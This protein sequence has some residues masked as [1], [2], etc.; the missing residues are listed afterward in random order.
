MFFLPAE[1]PYGE[2]DLV[3]SATD[4]VTGYTCEYAVMRRLDAL[5]GRIEVEPVKDAMLR[6]VTDL[7]TRH[8]TEVLESLRPRGVYEVQASGRLSRTALLARHEDTL[9]ALAGDHGVIY[10]ASFFDGSFHG[11]AD[12]L[13]REQD[14]S[15]AVHDTKLA[16]SAKAPALMQLAA[17]ADQLET[18]GVKVHPE[19][20]LILGSGQRSS[21]AL[22]DLLPGYRHARM[23]LSALLHDHLDDEDP[24]GWGDTRWTACLTC[25]ECKAAIAANDD[26]MLI[27]GMNRTRRAR[28][29]AA[30]T[31]TMHGFAS[32]DFLGGDRIQDTLY[33]QARLQCGMGN[34]AGTINGVSFRF[35]VPHTLSRI[36]QADPGDIFFDFE[37]DPLYQDPATKEWGLEY[38][39]G[40]LEHGP[41]GGT[42]F[43]AFTAHDY[44]AEKQALIDFIT[45][46][47]Q[48]V[49]EHPGL[50]IY[51][52]ASYEV[53]ALRR[54]AARHGVMSAEVEWLVEAGILFDLYEIVKTSLMISDRSLSIKKLEP[55][56]MDGHRTGTAT[57]LDSIT[58]YADYRA[59][60][61]NGDTG[62]AESIF[63]D[64]LAYNEYDC[65]STMKLRDWLQGLPIGQ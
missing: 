31:D 20:V 37:G 44:A 32:T 39:F 40:L 10:Q 4:I 22:S 53:T 54:L 34:E 43:T 29:I 48:Q 1:D 23:H 47:K 51:H 5:T 41:R 16:R 8:E 19:A 13:V 63:G 60:D 6:V 65:L 59:A 35:I 11:A 2:D 14:G 12:F 25:A 57:A 7:G 50:H 15:W 61:E 18:A 33:E 28:L 9:A 45:H 46:V 3:I 55:L 38:L 58:Q 52:Y 36:P 62:T 56:Y 21:H 17:Y 42:R 49:K 64:I 24:A 30:G 26:L 27:G